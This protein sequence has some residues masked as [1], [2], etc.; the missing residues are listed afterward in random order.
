HDYDENGLLFVETFRDINPDK[1]ILLAG[2]PVNIMDTLTAAGLDGC[3]HL[4]SDVIKTIS[5]VQE[6]VQ[7]NIKSLQV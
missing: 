7:R 6:K 5:G 1:V 4:K 3:I 2:N